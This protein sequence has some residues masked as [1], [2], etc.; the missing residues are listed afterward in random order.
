HRTYTLD[1]T[2]SLVGDA[3]S[4]DIRVRGD[5]HA[6]VVDDSDEHSTLRLQLVNPVVASGA[7]AAPPGMIAE[8]ARPWFV[9][10][11]GEGRLEAA[12]FE[13]G[14]SRASRDLLKTLAAYLQYCPA[15]SD[16]HD[17]IE[18]DSTGTYQADYASAGAHELVRTKPHY[19]SIVTAHGPASPRDVG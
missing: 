19:V 13:S 18:Q 6:T 1:F 9:E 16:S 14:V 5:W 11:D 15:D 17:R 4:F 3:Q 2:T 8:M 10:L 12:W 7:E